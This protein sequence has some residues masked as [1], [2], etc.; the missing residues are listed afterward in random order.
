MAKEIPLINL[1][2]LS[3]P[4]LICWVIY[5]LWCQ[6]KGE[7]LVATG[8]MV[9]QLLLIGYALN[10]LFENDSSWIGLGVLIVMSIASSMIAVRPFGAHARQVFTIAL[11]AVIV[12]SVFLLI[13]IL[14][15]V[16]SL[17][18][19]YEPRV[20]I[21]IAGMTF[22]SAMNSISISGER[23]FN[24]VDSGKPVAEA[25][26]IAY[27]AAM[28]PKVNTFLAVGIV[29]L[30]GMMTGQILAGASPLIAVRYQ[31]MVMLMLLGSGG[32]ASAVFLYQ[33]ARTYKRG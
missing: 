14:Y 19:I 20:F 18:K 4:L 33:V 32:I 27:K 17:E 28:I 1:L 30:P 31:I 8:R 6:K 21:P 22:S 10:F 29:S 26:G 5:Y 3:I 7:L 12:S 9:I 25:R 11:S 2:Y 23:Y 15:G 16:L 13:I 24:E